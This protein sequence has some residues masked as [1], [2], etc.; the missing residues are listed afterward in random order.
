VC[1]QFCGLLPFIALELP[2]LTCGKDRYDT[3]PVFGLELFGGVDNDEAHGMSAVYSR[4]HTCDIEN[5]GCG[6]RGCVR[7]FRWYINAGFEEGANVRDSEE[8]GGGW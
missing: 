4:T 5:C 8:R 1:K 3:R 7:R 6:A 2:Y